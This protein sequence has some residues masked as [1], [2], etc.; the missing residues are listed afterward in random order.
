MKKY[1]QQLESDILVG[2][3]F[4]LKRLFVFLIFAHPTKARSLLPLITE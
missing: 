1:Y 4:F 2:N 3:Y